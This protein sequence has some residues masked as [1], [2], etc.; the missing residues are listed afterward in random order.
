MRKDGKRVPMNL[1]VCDGSIAKNPSDSFV[2][3]TYH[4]GERVSH[5]STLDC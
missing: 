5:F 2:G 4:D 3:T 1:D